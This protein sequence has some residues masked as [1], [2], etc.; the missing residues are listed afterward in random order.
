MARW[1][2]GRRAGYVIP[3]CRLKLALATWQGSNSSS[4]RDRMRVRVAGA[5][6]R[7]RA[8]PGP[9]RWADSDSA[10]GLRVRP[11]RNKSAREWVGQLLSHS[12]Q[13][14]G[15]QLELP[16][17][18]PAT[19]WKL[20][21]LHVHSMSF[22]FHGEPAPMYYPPPMANVPPWNPG[23]MSDMPPWEWMPDGQGPFFQPFQPPYPPHHFRREEPPYGFEQQ[24]QGP[25]RINPGLDYQVYIRTCTPKCIHASFPQHTDS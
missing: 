8:D 12:A 14:E 19:F 18:G 10:P 1:A 2:G 17:L 3:K 16:R 13:H 9:D 11:G 21:T 6:N 5:G 20:S 24:A 22:P 4:P 25:R 15:D 23:P 7:A